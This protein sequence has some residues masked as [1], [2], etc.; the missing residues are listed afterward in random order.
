[1]LISP[2]P[3]SAN[4]SALIAMSGDASAKVLSYGD[5]LLRK[6]DLDLLEDPYEWLN[7]QVGSPAVDTS[8]TFD[9]S[10]S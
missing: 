10:G 5:I 9:L 2:K 4:G 1:M 7:D 8:W 3:S 6:A